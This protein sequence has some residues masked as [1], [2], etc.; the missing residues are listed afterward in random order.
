MHPSRK[1][2]IFCCVNHHSIRLDFV[3]FH[4]RILVVQA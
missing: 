2:I 4:N 1:E 3:C